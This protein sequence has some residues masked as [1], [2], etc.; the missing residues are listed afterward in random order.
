MVNYQNGKIYKIVSDNTDKIYIGSTTEK[1]LSRRLSGHNRDFK[2][3]KNYSSSQVLK[4]GNNSIILIESFPCNSVDELC[5]RERHYIETL[6]CVNKNVPTRTPQEYRDNIIIKERKKAYDKM[7]H[8]ENA[9]HKRLISNKY[10][11]ENK[12]EVLKRDKIRRDNNK[13]E[14]SLKKR[15]VFNCECGLTY[16]RDNK[17]RHQ[18]T[19]RHIKLINDV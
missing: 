18:R 13:E 14:R 5:K 17:A 10:Y 16:T 3:N 19:Q 9:E 4:Y 7:Y 6:D 11:N 2:S 1:Y 12:V 15:Q 8:E